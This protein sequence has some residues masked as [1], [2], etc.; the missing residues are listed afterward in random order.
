[1]DFNV[2][3]PIGSCRRQRDRDRQTD[4]DRETLDFDIVNPIRSAQD[5]QRGGGGGDNFNVPSTV[6]SERRERE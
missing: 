2:V 6:T 1:M 4:I 5:T 3:N